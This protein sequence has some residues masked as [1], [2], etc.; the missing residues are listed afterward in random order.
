VPARGVV[1]SAE[2]LSTGGAAS[3]PRSVGSN[4]TAAAPS[5]VMVV[6][7]VMV[8]SGSPTWATTSASKSDEETSPSTE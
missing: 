8:M 7:L 2:L 4:G 5:K 6:S 3:T 1:T